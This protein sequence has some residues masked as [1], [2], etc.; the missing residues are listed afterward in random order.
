M[1]SPIR[2]SPPARRSEQPLS[3][4]RVDKDKAIYV[5]L[6]CRLFDL[7]DEGL[8]SVRSCN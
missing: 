8:S 4:R 1:L 2:P 6:V 3:R 7:V 5:A